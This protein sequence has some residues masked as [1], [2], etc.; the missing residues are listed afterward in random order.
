MS[1]RHLL[2]LAALA[3][4]PQFATAQFTTF[5]P[6]KNK[7]VDSVKAAVVAEQKAH[8]DTAASMRLTNMKTWV[9]SAAGVLPVPTTAVD[10]LAAA[11][12]ASDTVTMRNGA[13]A[14]ATASALPLIALLGATMLVVGAMLLGG[15]RPAR[16]RDGT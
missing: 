12:P 5:I 15:P 11:V 9:D 10:S 6:P 4:V 14:P 7:V 8:A 2:V 3:G 13:R 16:A 1:Y